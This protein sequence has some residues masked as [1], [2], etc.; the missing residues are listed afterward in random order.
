VPISDAQ[1]RA[2]TEPPSDLIEDDHTGWELTLRKPPSFSPQPGLEYRDFTIRVDVHEEG[3]NADRRAAAD[4][5]PLVRYFL[6][7]VAAHGWE[8]DEPTDFDSL[9]KNDRVAYQSV[10]GRRWVFEVSSVVI[11]LQRA[12]SS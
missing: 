5:N 4:I 6:R 11:R 1:R 2:L 8:P 7:R 10:E 9:F 3:R 12:L